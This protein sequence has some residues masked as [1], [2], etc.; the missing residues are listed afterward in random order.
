MR[1]AIVLQVAISAAVAVAIIWLVFLV[2]L[3]HARKQMDLTAEQT[4]GFVSDLQTAANTLP[5]LP[6]PSDI[7]PTRTDDARIYVNLLKSRKN[8]YMI[9]IPKLSLLKSLY[10][11]G[12]INKYNAL[13]KDKAFTDDFGKAIDSAHSANTLITHQV[14]VMSALTNVFEYNPVDDMSSTDNSVLLDHLAA[15][16][17]GLA[18]VRQKLQTGPVIFNDP[19]LA[20]V[21]E[22]L[23]LFEAARNNYATALQTGPASTEKAQY[24]ATASA[25]QQT[26]INNR[27]EFWQQESAALQNSLTQSAATLAPWSRDLY[28]KNM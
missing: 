21:K 28:R 2:P 19:S 16:K 12:Y 4:A 3:A 18:K 1:P 9:T 8:I 7:T 14:A 6:D 13:L 15:A 22:Q 20:G 11:D 10:K 26:I 5:S 17:D 25:V 24:I 23:D 27:Q